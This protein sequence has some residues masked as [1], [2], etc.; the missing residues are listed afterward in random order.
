M[1]RRELEYRIHAKR[2]EVYEKT[3]D[4]ERRY[5]GEA[6]T[7][8]LFEITAMEKAKEVKG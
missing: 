6:L 5:W 4:P 7:W 3:V 8:V 1:N 2:K